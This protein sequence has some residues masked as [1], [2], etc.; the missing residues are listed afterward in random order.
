[1]M[2]IKSTLTG[3]GTAAPIVHSTE[4]EHGPG[5]DPLIQFHT[6]WNGV[7]AR[8]RRPIHIELS[9]GAS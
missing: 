4:V 6:D 2:K 8:L 7:T 9:P 3:E 5:H 1:M